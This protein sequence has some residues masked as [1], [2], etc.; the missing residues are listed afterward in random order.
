[1]SEQREDP[2]TRIAKD[3]QVG[4]GGN[5]LSLSPGVSPTKNRCKVSWKAGVGAYGA[6]PSTKGTIE[7][8]R[9]QQRE[10]TGLLLDQNVRDDR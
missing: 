1:M 2:F 10:A 6:P 5:F 7:A 4:L 9:N 3:R 8:L